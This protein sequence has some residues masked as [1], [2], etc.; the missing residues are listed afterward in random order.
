MPSFK[1]LDSLMKHIAKKIDESLADE[2]SSMV[3]ETEQKHT[4][5]D[6]YAKYN[7]T[8]HGWSE[9]YVYDRRISDGGLADTDNMVATVNDG[10][11]TVTNVTKG[12]DGL[13]NLVGLIE[14][15]DKAGYGEYNYKTNRDGTAYQYLN[16]RPFIEN[17]RQEIK[18]KGLAKKS[19][20]E[21]LKNRGI[22]AI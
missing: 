19:L 1:D 7:V 2:V 16:P 6:V 9:P 5:S 11:L 10:I 21:G 4:Y 18:D 17:T 3:K 12:K 22:D 8:S 13:D 14:Y 20:V 15:G